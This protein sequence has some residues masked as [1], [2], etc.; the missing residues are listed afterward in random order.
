MLYINDIT[1]NITF[2]IRLFRWRYY[3]FDWKVMLPK[4][5]MTIC[6]LLVS[7][8]SG[9]L[10]IVVFKKTDALLVFLE[11]RTNLHLHIYLALISNFMLKLIVDVFTYPCCD[12]S[13]SMLAIVSIFPFVAAMLCRTGMGCNYHSLPLFCKK[14]RYTHCLIYE[15]NS[16]LS[17]S[18]GAK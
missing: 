1:E 6:R 8:Q 18:P 15:K 17:C 12:W 7:G 2:H 9:C 16:L 5:L 4:R 10:Y 13:W 3:N 14:W 11:C